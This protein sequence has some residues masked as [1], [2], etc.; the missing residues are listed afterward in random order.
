MHHAPMSNSN[1]YVRFRRGGRLIADAISANLNILS[2]DP[3]RYNITPPTYVTDSPTL[4]NP[5]LAVSTP[6][7]VNEKK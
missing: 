3:E 1:I 6:I 4:D 2:R 7:V 5:F